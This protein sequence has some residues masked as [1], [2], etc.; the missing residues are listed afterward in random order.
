MGSIYF[1]TLTDKERI[2]VNHHSKK[3]LMP[4]THK[5]DVVVIFLPMQILNHFLLFI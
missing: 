1:E 4:H 2:M 3:I 5:K